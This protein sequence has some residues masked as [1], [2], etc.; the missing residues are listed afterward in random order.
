MT[1]LVAL[2]VWVLVIPAVVVGTA[3]YLY[4]HQRR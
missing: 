1:L 3:A 2:F 4:L